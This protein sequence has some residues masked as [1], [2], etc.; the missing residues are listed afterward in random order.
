MPPIFKA[1]ATINAWFLFVLGWFAVLITLV[2][3]TLAQPPSPAAP[4]PPIEVYIAIACGI[5]SV[6]LSVVVMRLRQ[7]ME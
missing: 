7:K 3:Q 2:M 1:L 5:A 6:T 4:P